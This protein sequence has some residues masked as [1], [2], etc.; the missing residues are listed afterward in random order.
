MNIE[1]AVGREL[2]PAKDKYISKEDYGELC[3]LF[4][5]CWGDAQ[6]T[7][8]DGT[9]GLA[10]LFVDDPDP[11]SRDKFGKMANTWMFMDVDPLVVDSTIDNELGLDSEG[12][13]NSVG[14]DGEFTELE[15]VDK[16]NR[17]GNIK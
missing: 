6:M 8:E 16:L 2:V 9:N 11:L 12:N 13:S 10:W 14:V 15:M 4:S 3:R 17:E 1:D 5:K 7:A